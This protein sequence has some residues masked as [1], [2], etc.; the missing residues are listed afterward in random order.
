V[1]LGSA[2]A[3]VIMLAITTVLQTSY[4][5]QLM[6]LDS[7]QASDHQTG[8]KLMLA[9]Y[10]DCKEAFINHSPA[11][12]APQVGEVSKNQIPGLFGR[13]PA[14]P[15]SPPVQFLNLHAQV[16]N[17]SILSDIQLESLRTLGAGGGVETHA[18][19]LV[20][21]YVRS[22][23]FGTKGF[24]RKIPVTY[25]F[26]SGTR[27]LTTCNFTGAGGGGAGFEASCRPGTYYAPQ[28]GPGYLDDGSSPASV[29]VTYNG[30]GRTLAS[31]NP[32]GAAHFFFPE[33]ER[34]RIRTIGG[35]VPTDW[36]T[37]GINATLAHGQVFGTNTWWQE[38][39]CQTAT[40]TCTHGRL[41]FN[42]EAPPPAPT[43]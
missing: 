12:V 24:V 18:G 21:A 38:P 30:A 33:E 25:S 35:Q 22:R 36:N 1:L 9:R 13:D 7:A 14:A 3:S 8:V 6:M 42:C 2:I 17:A 27:K 4:D 31:G 5:T 15:T 34:P 20:L 23:A 37:L 19:N 10:N 28:I 11:L 40:V 29:T 43:P 41:S 16:S 39:Y 26:N 32:G